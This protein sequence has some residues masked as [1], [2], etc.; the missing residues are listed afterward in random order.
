MAK[1]DLFPANSS[2]IEIERKFTKFIYN[3]LSI[4]NLMRREYRHGRESIRVAITRFSA[5]FMTL[6]C[7]SEFRKELSQ[8]FTSTAW[9]ESNIS[10]TSVDIILKN[11]LWRNVEDILNSESLV[12]VLRLVDNE[13]RPAMRIRHFSLAIHFLNMANSSRSE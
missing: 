3:R 1:P 7:L 2:T 6:Q 11:T 10:D 9:V 4:L 13:Y 8:M 5:N 12:V